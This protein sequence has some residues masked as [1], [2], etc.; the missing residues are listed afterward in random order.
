MRDNEE[1]WRKTGEEGGRISTYKD[2]N[3]EAGKR[4]ESNHP[5]KYLYKRNPPS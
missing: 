4:K 3:S 2:L 5:I 1:V